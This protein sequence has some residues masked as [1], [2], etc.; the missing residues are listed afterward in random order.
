MDQP[1]FVV[2]LFGYMLGFWGL[3]S[4]EPGHGLN[5]PCVSQLRIFVDSRIQT[6]PASLFKPTVLYF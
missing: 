1:K 6:S 3:S 4:T 2:H 5:D